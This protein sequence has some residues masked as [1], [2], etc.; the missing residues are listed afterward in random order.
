MFVFVFVFV[1][2]CVFVFVFVCVSA[3]AFDVIKLIK[4]FF[5]LPGQN[6]FETDLPVNHE[7]NLVWP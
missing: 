4:N 7:I 6:I 2:V 1:F 3:C 5:F